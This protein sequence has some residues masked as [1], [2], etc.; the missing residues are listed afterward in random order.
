MKRIVV[1]LNRIVFGKFG[2]RRVN[3]LFAVQN[4][5]FT[6]LTPNYFLRL[7]HTLIP[8][9]MMPTGNNKTST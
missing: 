3:S 4:R 9:P 5:E 2:V 8:A 6:R 1:P 7:T